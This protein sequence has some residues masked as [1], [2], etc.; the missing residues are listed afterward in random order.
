MPMPPFNALVLV[1]PTK[2]SIVVFCYLIRLMTIP[3][4]H[5]G[6]LE[7]QI[8]MAVGKAD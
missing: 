7:Q 6:G 3:A 4:L 1:L 8:G 5:V 2:N